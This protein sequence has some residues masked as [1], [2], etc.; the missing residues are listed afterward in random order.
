MDKRDLILNLLPLHPT[1][2]WYRQCLEAHLTASEIAELQDD[3]AFLREVEGVLFLEKQRIM[4]KRNA[5]MELAAKKGSWQG[6]DK[7]LQEVDG[8]LFTIKKDQQDAGE[9]KVKISFYL[10]DNG[11]D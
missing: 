7:L 10:P 2:D 3:P 5:S 8:K 4:V 6:M 9:D 1:K 11:R